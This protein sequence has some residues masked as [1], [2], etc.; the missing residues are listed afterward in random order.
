MR[1]GS[2]SGLVS[3]DHLDKAALV[4][5]FLAGA[6]GSWGAKALGFGPFVAVAWTVGARS[7]V[8]ARDVGA[9]AA[10]TRFG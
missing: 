5:A 2:R 3:R 6:A 1:R 8:R 10:G 4:V 7:M 9:L